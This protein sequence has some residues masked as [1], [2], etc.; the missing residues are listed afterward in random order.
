MSIRTTVTLDEDVLVRTKAFSHKRG[1]PFKEALNELVRIGLLEQAKPL[2][3]K[4]FIKPFSVGLRPGFN[5]DKIGE[6][7]EELEGPLHK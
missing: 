5:Y 2:P 7:L 1:I 4:P 3:K 6:L